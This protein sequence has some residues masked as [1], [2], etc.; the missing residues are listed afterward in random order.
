[1][2]DIVASLDDAADVK[3]ITSGIEYGILNMCCSK[4]DST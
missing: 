2:D 4:V 1:M 3:A